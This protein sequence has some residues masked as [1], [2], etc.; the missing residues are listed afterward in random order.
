MLRDQPYL[1]RP[2]QAYKWL[3]YIPVLGL[4][5][6]ACG[7]VAVVLAT[8]FGPR[9]GTAMGVLWSR[10]NAATAPMMVDVVGDEKL[11]PE[12]SYVVVAN[13][14]SQFDIFAL[15]GWLGVD[16]KWVMKANLR[17]V[18]FLGFACEKL[19][20]VFIDRSDRAAALASINEA[21]ERIRG[22]TSILFFPEGTRSDDGRLLPFKKGAFRFALDLGLPLLPVT[23]VGTRHVLPN[24]TLAL[25]P[26]KAKLVIGDPIEVD[27]YGPD[28]LPA[29]MDAARAALQAALD[30]HGDRP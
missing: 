16:F 14:Q 6:A 1:F 17:R 5:T 11:D 13:H 19:G 20:H 18:P 21:R 22:G 10:L 9:V 27:G 26:G 29:L 12:R 15:Y 30:E 25:F 28:D 24:R 3:V 7:S 8:L 4:S 2:Y 23:L